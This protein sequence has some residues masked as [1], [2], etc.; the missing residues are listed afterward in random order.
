MTWNFNTLHGYIKNCI[1]PISFIATFC[2]GYCRIAN[3]D[4]SLSL[5]GLCMLLRNYMNI[6]NNRKK[7]QGERERERERVVCVREREKEE[8]KKLEQDSESERKTDWEWKKESQIISWRVS[9]VH[10]KSIYFLNRQYISERVNPLQEDSKYFRKSQSITRRLNLF[11]K[12]SKYSM[13]SIRKKNILQR[14]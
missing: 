9:L 1:N 8:G 11:Q 10:E 3:E 6:D 12:E 7:M 14:Q 5:H 13:T 4:L 2:Q